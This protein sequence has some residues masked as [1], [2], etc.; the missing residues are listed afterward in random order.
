[1]IFTLKDYQSDAV[2]DVLRN[3]ADARDDWHRRGRPVAF[4]LTAATG[5]G[6][7]VMASAVIEAL[8]YGNDDNDFQADPGAVVLWF[9][10][11]PALNEQTKSKIL[12]ASG[13]RI[14]RSRLQVIETSFNQ[15]KFEPGKVYFLNSQKLGKNSLLV[16]GAS[17][18]S[19]FEKDVPPDL[20][21]YTMWDTI[22]NTIDDDNVTL[23]LILDEA[24]KGMKRQTKTDKN[25]K[26]TIV[27]RL[28]NGANGVPPVPIVWGISAT[29]ER[30]NEAMQAALNRYSYPS[31]EVDP[32]SVQESGLLKDDIRLDF[33][34]ESGKFDT[35]LL[36]RGTRKLREVTVA[37]KTYATEQDNPGD[38]VVPMMVLQVPNTPSDA[39]LASAINA[40]RDEWPDLPRDAIAHVFGEHT[41]IT[42]GG[43]TI[44]YISPEKVQ[45]RHHIPVLLAKDA[46][47]TGWDCPRAEVMVSYRSASDHTHITQLLG[48]MVRTPLARR[49]S[50]NDAL[51]AVDCI[52]PHFNRKTAAEVGRILM[53]TKN[54]GDDGTGDTG[55]GAGRRVLFRPVD[56]QVNPAISEAVWLAFD[57][58]PSQ[59]L[60]RKTAKPTK[61]LAALAQALSRDGLLPDA[62]KLAYG[63]SFAVLDGLAARFAK[64]VE[65]NEYR[66]LGVEGETLK[67]TVGKGQV[68]DAVAFTEVADDRSV[69]ADFVVAK[70]VL[71][72]DLATKY[73]EHVAMPG[74]GDDGLF[75][76]HVKVAALAQ[77]EEVTTELEDAAREL[78][79]KW[80]TEHR[81][82]IKGLSDERQE[83]YRDI[84]SMTKEPQRMDIL[85]PK[86][87]SEDAWADADGTP[88]PN[89]T[90]HLMSDENGAFPIG[91]LKTIEVRVLDRELRRDTVVGWYRNPPRSDD[92]VAV[93][94]KDSN[95][96]WRRT[97]PDFVFF[98]EQDGEVRVSVVDPHGHHLPDALPKLR[99]LADFTE[100][101]GHGFHRIEAVSEMKNKVLRVL[102][103]KE[104]AVREAI[105][106]ANDA[107][108]LYLG[109]AAAN[110]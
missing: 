2:A 24:H 46:I 74:D 9:T 40:I 102:D 37:W 25:E 38:V 89:R 5:A 19:L 11:D 76:A 55:G 43:H 62:R 73:A 53:G 49:I 15:E 109:P 35:V 39:M 8:F 68:G 108:K 60:P 92:A 96:A 79:D 77:V 94:Y 65:E 32:A 57:S 72:A 36:R 17:D 98:H 44:S 7:T 4:S 48:R 50:G 91:S 42:V 82:A 80:L 14:T 86:V 10:D 75:D 103:L 71:T 110:Y 12:D 70:R 6:K 41:P 34:T 67:F 30:F 16:R 33:P 69:E 84:I 18:E 63:E 1:M 58:V 81:V 99:G 85:R 23:Y 22:R 28:V 13:E 51:N 26:E 95:G 45:D 101:F 3:L 107:E 54:A 47:S 27:R 90:M 64:Q 104:A 59:S 105:R 20:R 83:V 66:V 52:L 21:S 29:V 31:V 61:R 97:F 87:R 100:K 88:A 106:S 56:M 93:A 78:S